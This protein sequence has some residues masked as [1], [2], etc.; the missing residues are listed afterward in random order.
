MTSK[1]WLAVRSLAIGLLAGGIAAAAHAETLTDAFS[2]AYSTN[3]TLLAQR[4]SLRATDETVAQANAQWKPTLSA[5]ASV[6]R[7][8]TS[9]NTS[10]NTTPTS[11]ALALSQTLYR[12]G[13]ITEGVQQAEAQVLAARARLRTSEQTVLSSAVAAFMGVLQNQALLQLNQS[14][15]QV[16]INQL[17]AT[18]NRFQVGDATVTDV[19]LAQAALSAAA[20]SRIQ[21]E[22]N[23][24]AAVSSYVQVMGQAPGNLVAP[25]PM[26]GLPPTLQNVVSIGLAENP[27][28]IAAQY[29][30]A[31]SQHAIVSAEGAL[32][33]TVS[34][35]ART[36]RSAAWVDLG[37][38]AYA[39][40]IGISISV[41][42]YQGGGEYSTI[43]SAKESSVQ[44]QLLADDARRTVTQA[45]TQAWQQLAT[46][47]AS[48]LS[49]S[50]QVRASEQALAG[51]Q[52]ERE[53]GAKTL[54]DVL[55]AEQNLLN[56]R[57]A[58][59]TARRDEVVA[60]YSL[61]SAMGRLTAEALTL[62]VT[63]YN[64]VAH[65]DR[66]QDAWIGT[67]P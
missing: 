46:A 12:G 62:P 57:V 1:R 42:L 29:T 16:L 19:A 18:R 52:Q 7:S 33:P 17:E 20:A 5:T 24:Q 6:T 67:N 27:T 65:Y 3:P 23:L 64:A 63:P 22:G 36:S 9:G 28:V 61:L 47:R 8:N 15:E 31:A 43:R 60:S 26:K 34:A 10:N 32:R 2:L 56:A 13:R 44:S 41:P 4:A 35:T 49:R 51:V 50:D 30:L 39:N 21:A 11:V 25:D 38:P 53:V 37:T 54:L 55:T 45:A 59:V 58:L 66:V 48:I 40:S 14:N